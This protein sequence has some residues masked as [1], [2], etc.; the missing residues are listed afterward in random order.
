MT[1]A[2]AAASRFGRRG[3]GRPGLQEYGQL[4]A[5]QGLR[6]GGSSLPGQEPQAGGGPLDTA[7]KVA[8]RLRGS[9]VPH[10]GQSGAGSRLFRA[11]WSKTC[12][13]AP[14]WYS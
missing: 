4:P 6:E 3:R 13:Q 7:V 10:W 9:G 1:V 5:A 2:A 11:K 8:K 12:S 14:H